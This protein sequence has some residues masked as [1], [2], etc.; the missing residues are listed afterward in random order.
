MVQMS[1]RRVRSC[2]QGVGGRGSM[3][4][5]SRRRESLNIIYLQG[6]SPEPLICLLAVIQYK[7]MSF[8]YE[9]GFLHE[10]CLLSAQHISRCHWQ[11]FHH[12]L[13]QLKKKKVIF[14]RGIY[15][16]IMQLTK[17]QYI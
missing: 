8:T 13:H 14:P 2:K 4:Q 7:M 10:G 1:R 3:V 16:I 6:G 9:Q 12:H 5:M 11:L 17:G 15:I